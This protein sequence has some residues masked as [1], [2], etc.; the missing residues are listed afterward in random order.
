MARR[1]RHKFTEQEYLAF[2]NASEDRH[3]FIN[4]VILGGFHEDNPLPAAGVSV[5]DMPRHRFTPKEYLAFERASIDRHEY[6]DGEVYSM[7]R[8]PEAHAWMTSN[9]LAALYPQL[10]SRDCRIY[11]GN[12]RVQ[13]LSRK[14]YFYP[15]LVI[16]CGERAFADDTEDTLTN[17]AVLIEVLSEDSDV[18]DRADKLHQYYLLPSLQA[19]LLIS[20]DAPRFEMFWREGAGWLYS[21]F[22]GMETA[23]DLPS[24]GCTL[25]L[26]AV[27]QGIEF[28]QGE[29]DD[30]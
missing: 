5:A 26:S 14:G 1:R 18:F 23:V 4:G 27:Y 30:S 11:A 16:V 8:D 2:E 9:A 22:E 29:N 7:S 10:T 13:M 12:L 19:Y 15:D 20:H 3:E 6:L 28:N 17:P 25:P 24:V 21:T